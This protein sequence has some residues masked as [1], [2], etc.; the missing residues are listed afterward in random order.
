MPLHSGLRCMASAL[1]GTL[2]GTIAQLASPAKAA[3]Q[4]FSPLQQQIET[5]R[6]EHN[7][8]GAS[9]AVIQNG[10]IAWARVLGWPIWR[11]AGP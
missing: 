9:V 2:L 10:R 4:P 5:L 6:Q 8:P 11:A 1:M 7:I 3:T